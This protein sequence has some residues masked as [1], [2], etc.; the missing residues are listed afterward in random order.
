MLKNK[1][2]FTLIELLVV[3]AIIGTLSGIVLVSLGTAR[4]RARDAVRMSDMRQVVSA[5]ELSYG[6]TEAY[7]QDAGATGGTVAISTYLDALHDPQCP[8]GTCSG[9][10]VNYSW[11][12]NSATG[13]NDSQY[14][15]VYA[16]MENQEPCTNTRYFAAS[17]KGTKEICDTT[18][19]LGIGDCICW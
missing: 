19:S 16:T 15:C 4:S 12:N 8:A 3:I 2:G 13:C 6:I 11:E 18:P 9:T 17:E 7:V 1:R 14:F 5:Q 10:Q